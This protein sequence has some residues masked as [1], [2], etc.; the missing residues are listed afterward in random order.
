MPCLEGVA[1]VLVHG[2]CDEGI[3][4]VL[5]REF[6]YAVDILAAD[7]PEHARAAVR[8]LYDNGG[9]VL[10]HTA[11]ARVFEL[12]V[13]GERPE[14]R[15]GYAPRRHEP[16]AAVEGCERNALLLENVAERPVGIRLVH[17]AETG[18]LLGEIGCV[19]VCVVDNALWGVRGAEFGDVYGRS[20]EFLETVN[21]IPR[22][23]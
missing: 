7:V 19:E 22:G 1:A 16:E 2:L 13:E 10:Q 9:I 4:T 23:L 3:F 14:G 11:G 12:L 8:T 18:E 21:D 5:S 17:V 6:E 20:R 15:F